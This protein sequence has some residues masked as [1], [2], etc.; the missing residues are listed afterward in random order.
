MNTLAGRMRALLTPLLLALMLSACGGGGVQAD[1]VHNGPIAT[2]VASDPSA[3]SCSASLSGWSVNI[4]KVKV[5]T[6]NELPSTVVVA[7]TNGSDVAG[8]QTVGPGASATAVFT[9]RHT[10]TYVPMCTVGGTPL[11]GLVGADGV[12]VNK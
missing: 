4:G 8:T 1:P 6:H 7:W 11:S 9:F 10:G 2:A 3:P 5:A 12:E